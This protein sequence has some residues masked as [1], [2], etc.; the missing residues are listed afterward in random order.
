[1]GR[2]KKELSSL[3]I[4]QVNVR[5]TVNDYMKVS[6]DAETIGLSV[7]EYIRRK[8]TEKSLP[9]K[10]VSPSDR[11]IFVELS[12]VGNNLNQITKVV[13]SGIRDP[14][15]INRQLEEVKML[16]QYLKSNI[17]NNDR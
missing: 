9:K 13:N 15:I 7:A 5:M 2:P 12:R 4:I 3:K 16:L 11:K 17:A 6:A 1:M 10:R 8:I 14:F